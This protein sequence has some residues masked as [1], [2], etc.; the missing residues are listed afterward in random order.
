M[1]PIPQPTVPVVPPST[2]NTMEEVVLRRQDGPAIHLRL[3]EA[4]GA[5]HTILVVHGTSGHG[6]CYNRYMQQVQQCGTSIYAL[7]L[8]GHGQSQGERGVFTMEGFLEDVDLAAQFIKARTGLPLILL[9]ASQGGE[10]AYHASRHSTAVDGCV[11]MNL[12]LTQ[13][14]PLHRRAA[15]MG[16]R[17]A[18]WLAARVGNRV[19]IPLR[20]VIN[21][22]AAYRENPQLL[23]AKLQDPTYVW[24]Y[25]F[26]SYQSIFGYRPKGPVRANVP[27]LVACGERDPVV[28]ADHCTRVA[29]LAGA[30]L[31]VLP[32]A[33]HHL[34]EFHP[35]RFAQVV[36]HWIAQRVLQR[37][38]ATWQAPADPLQAHHEAFVAS[39]AA[40][41]AEEDGYRL[42]VLD[43]AL[44]WLC[45][46]SVASGVRFFAHHRDTAFG[47]FVSE[48]VARIDLTAYGLFIQYLPK[49]ASGA[50]RM[51]VLGC[52]EGLAIQRLRERYPQ[53]RDVHIVGV[54]VDGAAIEAARRR[55]AGD[56]TVSFVVGDARDPGVLEPMAFDVIHNH[57]VL[58]HCANH[59][60]VLAACY[61]GLKP[62][63]VLFTI[64]PDRNITTWASFVSVGPRFI[65][66]LGAQGDLHD[67]RRF[68]KPREYFAL[69]RRVGFDVEKDPARPERPLQVGIEYA[70]APW[71]IYCAVRKRNHGA[72]RLEL[73]PPRAWLC[74]G[75]FGEFLS[76]AR[77]P[78]V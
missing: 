40:V 53:L 76:V 48:V 65:F 57:G 32:G 47:R 45:N 36:D 50:L 52:G 51:A 14:R 49:R 72:M 43:R 38:T 74:G 75:H 12:L 73:R 58:D 20:A 7:D 41:P 77:R 2:V 34:M 6:G 63:G 16:S 8:R 4:P 26:H 78:A 56:A 44:A 62:G 37:C 23:P 68:P 59:R 27:T 69:L 9:G 33:G 11:S 15:F 67:Y 71:S 35:R 28:G 61:A 25:G 46:G 10:V 22:K 39:H 55:F 17:L 13:Q 5:T 18:A 60:A 24:S 70:N 31:F 29:A 30:D 3:M 64:T 66:G 21:F 54:D 19:R 42:G 1:N